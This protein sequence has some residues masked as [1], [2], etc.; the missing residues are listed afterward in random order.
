MNQT[1]G[2]DWWRTGVHNEHD[3]VDD[4]DALSDDPH[5]ADGPEKA[6]ATRRVAAQL[7]QARFSLE[8]ASA[9]LLWLAGLQEQ[10]V[11][12]GVREAAP[13]SVAMTDLSGTTGCH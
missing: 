4:L 3:V 1:E 5:L 2:S 13:V 6:A 12:T 7:L 8:Y 11:G 9:Q 10:T